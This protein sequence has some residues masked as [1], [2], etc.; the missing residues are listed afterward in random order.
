[1]SLGERYDKAE[2][3]VGHWLE[4]YTTPTGA[5]RLIQILVCLVFLVGLAAGYFLWF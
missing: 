1:M 5:R 3:K 4:P 2:K